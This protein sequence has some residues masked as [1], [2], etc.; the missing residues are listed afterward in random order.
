MALTIRS[1]LEGRE[2]PIV[3]KPNER[4]ADAIEQMLKHDYSQLPVVDGE[5]RLLGIV[6]SDSILHSVGAFGL[7]PSE[8]TV[9]DAT[10]KTSKFDPDENVAEL[11]DGLRDQY[12]AVIVDGEGKVLGVVT[13]F[14]ASE[15]FRRR[16]EDMMLVEDIELAIREHVLSAYTSQDGKADTNKLTAAIAKSA[17]ADRS[18]KDVKGRIKQFVAKYNEFKAQD[19]ASAEHDIIERAFDSAYGSPKTKDFDELTL[20]NYVELLLDPNIWPS[21]EDVF[22]IDAKALRRLF[23][24]VRTTRN[25]LAHFR[26]EI[27]ATD[28]SKLKICAS[29]LERHP[30]R[31]CA[32]DEVPPSMTPEQPDTALETLSIAPVE[33]EPE[34]GEGR[35]AKLAVWLQGKSSSSDEVLTFEEVEEIIQAKLPPSARAHRAWWANDSV[36]H[37]Q[38]KLWLEVGWRVVYVELDGQFVHFT[39]MRDRE[40]AYIR[41]FSLVAGLLVKRA[42]YPWKGYKPTG[43]SWH[44]FYKLPPEKS[45]AMLVCSFA[46]GGRLRVELYID[47]QITERNKAIFDRL[48]A[49]SVH[50]EHTVGER[51]SWERLESRRA[52]RI[53][54][55]K[56]GS[57]AAPEVALA[58]MAGWAAD[59]L[60]LFRTALDGPLERALD[61]ANTR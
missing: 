9:A 3:A 19:T 23:N 24:D 5:D 4:L 41:F 61:E 40:T 14:D 30:P 1:L 17:G 26:R 20:A 48:R 57:I 46:R 59:K 45:A 49:E 6:T 18:V 16:A 33:E 52:S 38:S 47:T 60:Q 44:P 36:S 12:A 31:K 54:V 7:Q 29:W 35:Y 51:V 42:I 58:D 34:S 43:V 2:R 10:L 55:Y 28:R 22:R 56:P 8:L 25:A 11:F 13:N 32:R 27:S 39:R 50:I 53:A 37:P 15:Y 21:Y